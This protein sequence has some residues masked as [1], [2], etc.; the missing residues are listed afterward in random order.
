M[1]NWILSFPGE[2]TWSRPVSVS[3]KTQNR[4]FAARFDGIGRYKCAILR[5]S[6]AT[7]LLLFFFLPLLMFS[8][9]PM[10]AV[11]M[12][13]VSGKN[14]DRLE[15]QFQTQSAAGKKVAKTKKKRLNKVVI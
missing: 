9:L 12:E 6:V 11:A 3:R 15:L 8:P 13:V 5:E 4:F 1:I 2:H 7:N 10:V 14:F